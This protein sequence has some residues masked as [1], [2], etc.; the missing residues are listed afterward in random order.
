MTHG[1]DSVYAPPRKVTDIAECDFYHVMD[2]PGYGTLGGEWD[3]RGVADEYLGDV[4]FQDK[5]VLEIGTASG[6]LCFHMERQGADVVAYDLSE[7][8]SWDVVPFA[9]FDHCYDETQRRNH[10][11][12]LNNAFWLCHQAY[13]SHARVVYG[14]VYDIPV[15]IG[16]VDIAV[17]GA[18]L[19]H[20]RDPFLALQ[21]GLRLTREMVVITEMLHYWHN[22]PL[23]LFTELLE[24][25]GLRLPL[26]FFSPDFRK[27]KAYNWWLLT[28][29]AV[30]AFI[31]VLGFEET[32][33]KYHC[34]ARYQGRRRL[35]YTVVGRRTN[36][37]GCPWEEQGD[38]E[39]H[40]SSADYGAHQEERSSQ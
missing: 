2:I 36:N 14:S 27:H 30:K 19:L 1:N 21:K 8:Y 38:G 24:R 4:D 25:F 26:V 11:R 18:V 31:G 23:T 16:P 22:L 3:L 6:F 5:R 7:D 33:V 13:G 39:S 28:P 9:R 37:R 34:G 15:G 35:M 10:I 12:R 20:F 32:R 29:Q 17:Y 40:H